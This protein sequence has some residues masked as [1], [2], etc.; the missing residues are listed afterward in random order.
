VVPLSGAPRYALVIHGGAGTI[1]RQD[2][3]PA[4]ERAYTEALHAVLAAGRAVLERGGSALDAVEAAVVLFEDSPLWNC[5]HG[6]V[7]TSDGRN[8][9]DAAIMDGRTLAAGAVA[10]L[11]QVRNPIRL[12]RAVMERSPHVML[13]GEGAE[14]F[15]REQGIEL[16]EARYFWTARRWAQLLRTKRERG[17]DVSTLSEDMGVD[18]GVAAGYPDDRE[19]GTVGAVACDVEGNLAAATSTGGMTNKRCGRVGDSPLIGAGTYADNRS[20]AASAT[21]HGEVFIRAVATH[22]VAARML[23]AGRT[24]AEAAEAVVMGALVAVGGPGS[25]GLV[26]V[27]ARGNVTAPFNGEGMYRGWVVAGAEPVVKMYRD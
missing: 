21:G 6:A 17:E 7:F 22:D 25:G 11:H 18:P 5:G 12:A 16:V 23:Y 10:G 1:R 9:L 19:V 2:M 13:V 27:D 14:R 24:L 4:V 8:E 26:A 3:T 15:A 20:C